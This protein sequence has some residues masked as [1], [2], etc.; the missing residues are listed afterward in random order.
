MTNHWRELWVVGRLGSL[1]LSLR[2]GRASTLEQGVRSL[3]V[4]EVNRRP[5]HAAAA[6][7]KGCAGTVSDGSAWRLS[8]PHALRLNLGIAG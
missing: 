5:S 2:A 1:N 6:N 4:G 7:Y 3:A 8:D